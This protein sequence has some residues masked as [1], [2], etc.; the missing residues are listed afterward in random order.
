V[1]PP[2]ISVDVQNVDG[3]TPIRVEQIDGAAG[4]FLVLR[5][6]TVTFYTD[7]FD[8]AGVAA[9][10]AFLLKMSRAIETFEANYLPVGTEL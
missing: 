7:G 1:T 4:T 9:M 3:D 10:T 2:R 6:G 8:A 5:V